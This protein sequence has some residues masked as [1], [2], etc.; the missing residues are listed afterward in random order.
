MRSKRTLM[1][2][3]VGIAA[4]AMI[5]AVFGYL[6]S[7]SPLGK[8]KNSKNNLPS[9]YNADAEINHP[10]INFLLDH[11]FKLLES[12]LVKIY[13][14]DFI[15][16]IIVQFDN[17]YADTININEMLKIYKK[18]ND[19][20]IVIYLDSD[21]RKNISLLKNKLNLNEHKIFAR[22]CEIKEISPS[23]NV[24]FFLAVNNSTIISR[25]FLSNS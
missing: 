1:Y 7:S 11:D 6:F 20:T 24:S 22:N 18:S 23:L 10:V 9:L 2:L 21:I 25:L 4:L 14:N 17:L 3:A 19:N 12:N 5:A 13:S 8:G 15:Q 16:V